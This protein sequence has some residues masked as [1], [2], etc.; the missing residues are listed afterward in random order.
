LYSEIKVRGKDV[1]E[2]LQPIAIHEMEIMYFYRISNSSSI[3]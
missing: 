1:L 2:F 3:S